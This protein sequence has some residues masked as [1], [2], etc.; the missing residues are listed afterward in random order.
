MYLRSDHY[1]H[2]GRNCPVHVD[3]YPVDDLV[4]I[5]LGEHRNAG[6]TFRIIVDHPDTCVR[7]AEA[8]YDAR[9]RLVAHKSAQAAHAEQAEHA[10]QAVLAAGQGGLTDVAAGG[11]VAL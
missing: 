1:T 3:M 6:N 5:A 11:R 8:L 7:L 9:N 2:V 10:A 4:E